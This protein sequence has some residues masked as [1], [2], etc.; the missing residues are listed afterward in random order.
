MKL[1]YVKLH[2]NQHQSVNLLLNKMKPLAF[3]QGARC[4]SFSLCVL[5]K[6]FP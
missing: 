6:S 3:L 2:I 1:V 4:K 5:M